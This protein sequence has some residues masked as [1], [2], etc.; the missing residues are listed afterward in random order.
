LALNPAFV[1][2]ERERPYLTMRLISVFWAG[3]NQ[4]SEFLPSQHKYEHAAP[5]VLCSGIAQQLPI[6]M[7]DRDFPAQQASIDLKA[8]TGRLRPK[9]RKVRVIRYQSPIPQHP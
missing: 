3:G 1:I 2:T 6:H 4:P 7:S 9:V 8:S 5:G